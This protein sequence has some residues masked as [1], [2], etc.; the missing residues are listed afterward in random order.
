[1]IYENILMNID[2]LEISDEV[3]YE[4]LIR[5]FYEEY[6]RKGLGNIC[7]GVNSSLT[8][9]SLHLLEDDIKTVRTSKK[10]SA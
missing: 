5:D 9:D 6:H 3:K 1:M 2:S 8:N 10:I 7:W 4:T